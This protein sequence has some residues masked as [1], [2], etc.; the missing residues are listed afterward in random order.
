VPRL[1]AVLRDGRGVRFPGLPPG[2]CPPSREGVIEGLPVR[3][4]RWRA[5]YFEMLGYVR[6][7]PKDRWRPKDFESRRLVEAALSEGVRREAERLH[8]GSSMSCW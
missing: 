7:I 3:C 2:A 6:D 4:V 8:D 1:G 5:I